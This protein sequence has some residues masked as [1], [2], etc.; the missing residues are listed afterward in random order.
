MGKGELE[1]NLSPVLSG[2]AESYAHWSCLP[3]SPT[4]RLYIETLLDRP[5]F[6][7]MFW[8]SVK[9]VLGVIIGQLFFSIPAAW[10][11]ARYEFPFR[12]ILFSVYIIL[13]MLPFQVIMLSEYLVFDKLQLLDTL[14][15]L[16]LPGIFSTFPV[17]IVHNFLKSIPESVLE[18]GRIDGANELQLF[19]RIGIPLGSTGII[20]SVILQFLEY[21]NLVEQ[22]MLF[23]KKQQL[24]PLSLYISNISL[25]N[26]GQA[27]V[28]SVLTLIP[29]ILIFFAGRDY[30]EQGISA[31]ACKE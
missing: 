13:M 12:K 7:V 28:S 4:L 9:I 19:I 20:A 2:A 10:G 22:P 15:A 1:M 21:W 30:L 16:I 14:W 31:M 18:A 23:L 25:D 29:S 6:F 5:E 26:A 17:F 3:K 8:N 27:L 11:F 24:W